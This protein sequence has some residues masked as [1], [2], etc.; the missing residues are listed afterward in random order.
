MIAIKLNDVETRLRALGGRVSE[1]VWMEIRTAAED[2]AAMKE[3]AFGLE[4]GAILA[5]PAFCPRSEAVRANPKDVGHV[6]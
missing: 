4:S 1:D 6:Q 5:A 2:L 3:V